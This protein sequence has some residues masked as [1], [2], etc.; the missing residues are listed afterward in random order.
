MILSNYASSTLEMN[1]LVIPQW[2]TTSATSKTISQKQKAVNY[3]RKSSVLDVRLG[4]EFPSVAG[5]RMFNVVP[6]VLV[7][8]LLPLKKS[9]PTAENTPGK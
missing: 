3:F 1:R 5:K 2:A 7:T 6:I 8:L 9:L 4:S